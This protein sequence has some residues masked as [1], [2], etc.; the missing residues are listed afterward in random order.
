MRPGQPP[1]NQYSFRSPPSPVLGSRGACPGLRPGRAL[2]GS[3]PARRA[4]PLASRKR[5]AA[6]LRSLTR[7]VASSG[8]PRLH[9]I[10]IVVQEHITTGMVLSGPVCY[11][12]AISEDDFSGERSTGTILKPCLSARPP[13]PP[14]FSLC[15]RTDVLRLWDVSPAAPLRCG[16]CRR[17]TRG[18]RTRRHS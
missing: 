13:E 2:R 4:G 18:A 5:A 9:A 16:W 6:P 17:C 12:R 10:S 15:L 8:V 7:V 11:G 3:R 1:G 14:T